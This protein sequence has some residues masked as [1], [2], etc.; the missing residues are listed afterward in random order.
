MEEEKITLKKDCDLSV[1]KEPIEIDLIKK[2]NDYEELIDTAAAERAPHKIAHYV[3]RSGRAV[4]FVLQPVPCPGRGSCTPAGP[5]GIDYS[6]GQYPAPRFEDPGC[7]CTG[8]YVKLGESQKKGGRKW[9][10][11]FL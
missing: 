3:L 1:L 11:I 9:P 4:P 7:Q 2:L 5:S 10:S 8:P 6:C